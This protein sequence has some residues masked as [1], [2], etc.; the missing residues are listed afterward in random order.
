MTYNPEFVKLVIY[1]DSPKS[2]RWIRA[3]RTTA[4]Y[5]GWTK[6]FEEWGPQVAYVENGRSFAYAPNFISRGKPSGGTRI[7]ICRS[8]STQGH[9]AGLTN[10]F[11]ISARIRMID[12][13]ELANFTQVDWH[14][15]EDR[16]GRR[17]SKEHWADIYR[18]STTRNGRGLVLN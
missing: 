17:V 6:E 15:M 12:L 10:Q 14:W 7:R 5:Y 11:T 2:C 16:T 3:L 18:G 8:K 13:A 9:P 4:D 1:R